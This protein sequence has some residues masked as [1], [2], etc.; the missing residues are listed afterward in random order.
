VASKCGFRKRSRNLT[1]AVHLNQSAVGVSQI[2]LH[3]PE[4]TESSYSPVSRFLHRVA[5]G[6][7]WVAEVSFDLEQALLRPRPI[8]TDRHVFV[9]GLA[10]AGT[11]ILMQLLHDSGA[12]NTLTYRH[13]PFVLMPGLWRKLSARQRQKAS[14]RERAHGDGILVG[15]DSP[16]AFEEVFWTTQCPQDYI[17]P[18]HLSEHRPDAPHLAMFKRFLGSVMASADEPGHRYLS[19]NNNNLLRLPSLQQHLPESL[20]LVPFRDPVQHSHSLLQQHL[21]FTTTQQGDPFVLDYMRWLGHFEF[22]GG[23]LPFFEPISSDLAPDHVDYWLQLWIQVYERVLKFGGERVLIISYEDLC[24]RPE[25]SL[26]RL[27]SHI[28]LAADWPGIQLS[29]PPRVDVTASASLTRKATEI[30]RE[31]NQ[32]SMLND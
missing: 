25:D 22:G 19:K 1:R 31:L 32:R 12:F 4:L 8:S 30:F 18:D 11:T 29:Y 5:L 17:F 13:M 16:E 7:R 23:H 3:G 6:N 20:F 10:R 14:L 21:R 27:W 2:Q 28:R 9:S 24:F 26:R 15:F